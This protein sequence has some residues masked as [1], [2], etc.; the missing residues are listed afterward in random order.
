[1]SAGRRRG[2]RVTG[3]ELRGR[4][5]RVPAGIRPSGGRLR[6]ALG[7]LWADRLPGARVLE[8]YAG[9]GGV[10]IEL[11]SR[12]AARA[13]FVE[14][15]PRV[16]AA[17]TDNCRLLPD[18]TWK[19]LRLR[20]PAGFARL[21]G[22]GP[23]DLLFADPPYADEAA[24]AALLAGT[25]PLA[26]PGAELALEHSERAAPPAAH[27]GWVLLERRRYGDSALSLYRLGH[28]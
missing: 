4:T 19:V 13:V 18:G 6:E 25:A 21:A 20:L 11:L 9:A 22:E 24:L 17:L 27:G 5:L 12:G 28:G 3:G 8:L 2:V 14:A 15:D 10:G 23:F 1:M 7:S 16:A 26:V